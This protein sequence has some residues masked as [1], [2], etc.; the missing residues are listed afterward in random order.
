MKSLSKPLLILLISLLSASAK[1][2]S[3]DYSKGRYNNVCKDLKDDVLLYFVF[4]DTRTT[5]P[6]SEFDILTTI[7]SIN[8]AAIWLEKQANKN[9]VELNI[10]TDYYIGD[11]YSTIQK[12][13][14]G[15]TIREIVAGRNFEEGLL[16]LNRW[17]DNISRMIGESLY[18]KEKD[19]I[20]QQKRPGNKE[21]LIAFLRDEYNVESVA[22]MFLL[23]NYFRNDISL[24]INTLH[25][26]DVEFC[27]VSYKY[28]S[29][30]AHNFLSLFGAVDLYETPFRQHRK[31]IRLAADRYPDDIMQ[32]PYAK[33]IEDLHIG[34]FTEYM[35]GWSDE[36]PEED[37]PLL[38]DRSFIF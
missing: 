17:G 2:P 27:I 7:D 12:N 6:W 10:K 4:I 19:G 31:K 23:N 11:E 13:L 9:N 35:I 18:L 32:D 21:R 26:N 34:E 38:T 20:P 14:P 22:I 1:A 5:C 37:I 15:Q 30:I 16:A 25:N 24:A 29:E 3:T 8:A 36:L 28:P 33:K